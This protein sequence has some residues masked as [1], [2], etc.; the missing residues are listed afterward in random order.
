[1]TLQETFDLPLGVYRIYWKDGDPRGYSVAT[2][3]QRYDGSR[4]L[5][6]ANWT[7]EREKSFQ[8]TSEARHWEMI[9]SVQLIEKAYRP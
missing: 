3:G 8:A 1:M 6:P 2:I 5:A 4:W 9:E 7:C